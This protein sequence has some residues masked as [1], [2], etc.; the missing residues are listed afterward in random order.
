MI[1]C[2]ASSAIGPIVR[3]IAAIANF[4]SK[5]PWKMMNQ[6]PTASKGAK[7]IIARLR[8]ACLNRYIVM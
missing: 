5:L 7:E 3:L 8:K 4:P 2:T 6:M 1:A